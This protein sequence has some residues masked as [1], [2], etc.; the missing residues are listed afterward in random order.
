MVEKLIEEFKAQNCT[1]QCKTNPFARLD[2]HHVR[3]PAASPFCSCKT[4]RVKS[5]ILFGVSGGRE[6]EITTCYTFRLSSLPVDQNGEICPAETRTSWLHHI[7]EYQ[8]IL[9]GSGL[10]DTLTCSEH[11]MTLGNTNLMKSLTNVFLQQEDTFCS[12]IH[13]AWLRK[14]TAKAFF[15]I[16]MIITDKTVLLQI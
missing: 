7:L 1:Y 9:M 15:N 14:L 13:K 16:N 4:K 11:S 8:G 2:V 3:N 10:L 12:F 5:D 6:S